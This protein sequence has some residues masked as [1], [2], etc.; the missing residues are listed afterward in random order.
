VAITTEASS[1][2]TSAFSNSEPV[3]LRPNWS[4]EDAKVAI[5]AVYRQVFGNDHIMSSERIASAESLLCDRAI[6]VRD[7]VRAVAKSET[8][9]K[10]FLYPNYHPRTIELNFKHLLGR[11]PYDESEITEHVNCYQAE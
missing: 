1:L 9:K 5:R 3:E 4:P 11:A 10:K 7:F 6:T 2:G 8:Y